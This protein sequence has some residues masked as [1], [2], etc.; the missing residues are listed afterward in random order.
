MTMTATSPAA[1]AITS[2]RRA[3]ITELSTAQWQLLTAIQAAARPA[4]PAPNDARLLTVEDVAAAQGVG[5]DEALAQVAALI[6]KGVVRARAGTLYLEPVPRRAIVWGATLG[7]EGNPAH[8]DDYQRLSRR[9]INEDLPER[10]RQAN[11]ALGLVGEAGEAGEKIKKH[12]FHGHPLD[13]A[14]LVKE[15]GDALWYLAQVASDHG[16]SLGDIARENM[17]KLQGKRGRYREGFSTQ[18]SQERGEE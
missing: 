3:R 14:G 18:A 9:T 10:E 8:M 4:I 15:L 17:E 16:L 13:R 6:T 11:H 5:L 2:T 12:L 1:E 7:D